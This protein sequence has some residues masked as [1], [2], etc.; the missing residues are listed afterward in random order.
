VSP[1]GSKKP[2]GRM[3]SGVG[4]PGRFAKPEVAIRIHRKAVGPVRLF[5]KA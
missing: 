3:K 2:S 1:A 4:A 5:G